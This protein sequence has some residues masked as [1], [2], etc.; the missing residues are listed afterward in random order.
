MDLRIGRVL[1][2][3]A[4]SMYDEM[5]EN[6]SSN[7]SHYYAFA[8]LMNRNVNGSE[9]I[10]DNDFNNK[11]TP[12]W[13]MLFGKKLSNTDITPI[14]KKN[15]WEKNKIYD[16]YD[17]L[18]ANLH[19]DGNFFV[20]SPPAITGAPYHVYK[21]I[22][23]ANGAVSTVRPS[24]LQATTFQTPDGYKWRYITS[25]R[26]KDFQNYSTL[27]YAPIHS[28]S[29]IVSSASINCGI[30]VVIVANGG[31]KYSTYHNGIIKSAP[32][33]TLLQIS[34][35]AINSNNHYTNSAVYIYTEGTATSQ[36][37]EISKYDANTVGKWITLKTPVD[38]THI[39]PGV[40]KYKIS[41]KV[42]FNTDGVTD[43]VA[44]S[45]VNATTNTI[46][47]VV[48]TNIGSKISWANVSLQCNSSHGSGANLYAII[49][50]PG[51]HGFDPASELDMK[52]VSVHFSFSN[53][54]LGTI[55]TFDLEYDTVG[56]LKNPYAANNDTL[57]TKSVNRYWSNTFNQVTTMKINGVTLTDNVEIKGLTSG[58]L[59]RVLNTASNNSGVYLNIVGDKYF[60]NEE[61]VVSTT[62][63]TFTANIVHKPDVYGKDITPLYVQYINTIDRPI[64][65][66]QTESFNLLLQF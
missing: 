14:I 35:D 22:D 61:S 50:P 25:V 23:N 6:I 57:R 34:D 4:K 65:N 38:L 18:N 15:M 55:P 33:T 39:N 8:A 7:T 43:P 64:S 54:E 66:T 12:S 56:I 42:I 1:P 5:L 37:A 2:S 19:S 40:T 10:D 26:Y 47:S 20:F 45:V 46:H 31:S 3:F 51:G 53:T 24:I 62:G 16:R 59:G 63:V 17:N 30:E 21:C 36:F 60:A 48:V 29:E 32:S 28:N 58:A 13:K 49:P 9:I 27:S 52:G 44:Y 11:F 41:P